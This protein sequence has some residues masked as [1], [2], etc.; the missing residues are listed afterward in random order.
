MRTFNTI[1]CILIASSSLILAQQKTIIEGTIQD[2]NN[3]PLPFVNV[4]LMGSSDGAMSTGNGT[5][6]FKTS[7]MGKAI[8][9]ASLIGY[10]KYSQELDFRTA[11]KKSIKI[12]LKQGAVTMNE[13]IVTA[14]SYG[15]EKEKGMVI[16]RIDILTT[17]GG[18]TDIYQCL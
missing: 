5:F 12:I 17:P 16:N 15:S 1:L 6:M 4:F 11:G 3:N 10:D 14:S 9:M 8:L 2:E 7:Q 18:A 13:T